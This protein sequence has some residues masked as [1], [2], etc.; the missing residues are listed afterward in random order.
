MSDN[1]LERIITELTQLNVW[2]G[3]LKWD[4]ASMK[5]MI[6]DLDD[7]VFNLESRFDNL[8]SR[9]DNLESRFDNL[10]KE[11]K[12]IK[13]ELT[14]KID[15]VKIELSDK[16]FSFREEFRDYTYTQELEHT[17]TRKLFNQ[18]FERINENMLYQDKVDRI[19]R[20]IKWR[21]ARWSTNFFNTSSSLDKTVV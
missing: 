13:I 7:R 5:S 11:F 17:A 20:I 15:S 1:I 4:I 6:R 8:E 12:I 2:I 21:Q 9:F 18:A 14:N 10:E 19:E 3:S 16:I